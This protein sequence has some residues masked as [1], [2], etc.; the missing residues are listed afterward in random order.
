METTETGSPDSAGTIGDIFI[1]LYCTFQP[2]LSEQFSNCSVWWKWVIR[3][4]RQNSWYSS[5]LWWKT[6]E[7]KTKC[8]QSFA[9][10][11]PP[12]LCVLY[13]LTCIWVQHTP[14]AGQNMLF[15]SFLWKKLKKERKSKKFDSKFIKKLIFK[16]S[17]KVLVKWYSRLGLDLCNVFV[18]NYVGR[19]MSQHNSSYFTWDRSLLV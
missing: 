17:T 3:R 9:K 6:E 18:C 12:L 10:G 11:K 7:T 1:K 13:I 4:S 2:C 16:V 15:Q 8:G 19:V 14:N 5:G